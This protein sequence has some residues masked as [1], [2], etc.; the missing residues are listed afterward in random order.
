M[1]GLLKAIGAPNS[2][3]RRIFIY[4]D[5]RLVFLGLIIGNSI[6]VTALILQ[7]RFHIIPLDPEAYYLNYVPVEINWWYILL[8]NIGVIIISSMMLLLPSQIIAKISPAQTMR[9]E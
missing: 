8:L 4:M 6:A 9:Y 2:M 3:I 7:S 5:E 1:I